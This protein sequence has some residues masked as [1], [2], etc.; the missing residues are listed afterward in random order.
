MCI[1]NILTDIVNWFDIHQGFSI[2]ILTLAYTVTTFLILRWQ[3]KQFKYVTDPNIIVYIPVPYDNKLFLILKNIGGGIA[4]NVKVKFEQDFKGVSGKV[5]FKKLFD[6]RDFPLLH[7][8]E[9]VKTYIDEFPEYCKRNEPMLLTG[10]LEYQSLKRKKKFT[11]RININLN[12][13]KGL[14]ASSRIS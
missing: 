1:P 2:F 14:I 7:P 8:E 5:D 3:I 11:Y 12:A 9:E 4:K 13:Y 6:D 10:K